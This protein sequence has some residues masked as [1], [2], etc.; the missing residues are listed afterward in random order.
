[1]KINKLIAEFE[2]IESSNAQGKSSPIALISLILLII[3]NLMFLLRQL[4]KRNSNI[5]S[6]KN[7]TKSSVG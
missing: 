6:N 3:I 5:K 7:P 1:M 4:R 2:L